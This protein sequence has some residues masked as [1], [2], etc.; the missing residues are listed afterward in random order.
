MSGQFCSKAVKLE[1]VVPK[2]DFCN[3]P[4]ERE[5]EKNSRP[6]SGTFSFVLYD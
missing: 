4:N 3:E 6:T 5:K 1:R 2:R